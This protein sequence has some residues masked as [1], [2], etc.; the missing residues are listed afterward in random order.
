MEGPITF[1]QFSEQAASEIAELRARRARS[2]EV[3]IPFVQREGRTFAGQRK[4]V[5]CHY[6]V[7]EDGTKWTDT[8]YE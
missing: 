5:V 6:M 2:T 3:A 7:D 8:R 4:S 1:A